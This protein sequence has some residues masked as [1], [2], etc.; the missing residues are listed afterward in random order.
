MAGEQGDWSQLYMYFSL[1][2]FL[3][4]VYMEESKEICCR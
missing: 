2:S 1:I 4:D 3:S